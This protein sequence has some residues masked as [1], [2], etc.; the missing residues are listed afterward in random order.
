MDV[1]VSQFIPIRPLRLALRCILNQVL[2][3]MLKLPAEIM[4]FGFFAMGVLSGTILTAGKKGGAVARVSPKNGQL[5]P[6]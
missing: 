6:A 5:G 3:K 2:P 1:R 4:Y